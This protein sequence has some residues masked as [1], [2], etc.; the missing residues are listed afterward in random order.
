MEIT[1]PD[2]WVLT[3]LLWAATWRVTYLFMWEEGP[4]KVIMR[5]RALSGVKH[6]D[7]MPIAYPDGN[8]FAC[9]WCLSIWTSLVLAILSLTPAWVLLVPLAASAAAIQIQ[10]RNGKS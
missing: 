9:F 8:V 5:L 6:D 1:R 10:M 2:F 3:V 4:Y 7:D